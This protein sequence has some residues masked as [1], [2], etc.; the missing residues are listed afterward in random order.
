MLYR[1]LVRILFLFDPEQVHY[2]SLR[3]F[4]VMHRIPYFGSLFKKAIGV[5]QNNH[6]VAFLGL[7]FKNPVGLA[8]GFDK[9]ARFI[10]EFAALGFGFMEVGTVTPLPQPGNDTPRLFRLVKDHAIINRMGFNNRGAD[11]MALELQNKPAGFIVGVNIGKN[12]TTPNEEAIKD[13]EVCFQKLYPYA[14]YFV[15]NVSS[16]NTPGLRALQE[17]EP[18]KNLLGHLMKLRSE[19]VLLGKKQVPVLLKIAPDLSGNQLD[20]VIDLTLETNIDGIVATN[21]T[22]SREGLLTSQETIEKIGP[23]GLS[24]IPIRDRSTEVIR[25]ISEKSGG[26]I[27]IIGVGGIFSRKDAEQKFA[28]GA[29]VVQ[30][31]T[32]FIYQGPKLIADIVGGC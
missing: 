29:T 16:P 17:K 20:D 24:G 21:T 12:K 25:Y 7:T 15:I 1:F 5:R 22:I 11:A 6:P 3:V 30:L 19:Y 18:L 28:S 8:A 23:G 26:K 27:A 4:R 14:D 2:F 32:G 13:Y 10:H 9:D 31:Y